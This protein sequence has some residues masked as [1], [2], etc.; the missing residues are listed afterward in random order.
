MFL[1]SKKVKNCPSIQ[2]QTHF[3]Y[4]KLPTR[5]GEDPKDKYTNDISIKK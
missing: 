1:N 5:Q 2:P 3:P 4:A